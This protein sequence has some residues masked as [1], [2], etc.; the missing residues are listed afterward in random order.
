LLTQLGIEKGNNIKVVVNRLATKAL[1][2]HKAE[3]SAE[4]DIKGNKYEYS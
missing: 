2:D 3:E 1:D 4:I